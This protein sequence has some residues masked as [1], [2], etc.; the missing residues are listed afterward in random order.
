LKRLIT[1]LLIIIGFFGITASYYIHDKVLKGQEA[2]NIA[3]AKIENSQAFFFFSPFTASLGQVL[4]GGHKEKL[5]QAQE[6]VT[7]YGKVAALTRAIGWDLFIIGL[8]TL[9]F[10]YRKSKNRT[11]L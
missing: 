4:I 5:S 6:K 3:Q 7:K 8:L 10:V 9:P 1:L 11:T 2:I